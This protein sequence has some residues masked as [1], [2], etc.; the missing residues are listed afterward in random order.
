M[1]KFF[2]AVKAGVRGALSANDPSRFRAAGLFLACQH[3][4]ADRFQ[5]REAQ[6]NTAG[7]S[8]AGL[9]WF[10]RSGHALVC[11][12]CSLIHWFVEKPERVEE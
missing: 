6:L 4:K 7:A 12:N 10:N 11:T 2:K 3:C 1:S 8:A 9:D 5:S